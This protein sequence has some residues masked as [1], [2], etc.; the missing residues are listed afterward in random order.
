[1]I[2]NKKAAKPAKTTK[3]TNESLIK[4]WHIALF[5]AAGLLVVWQVVSYVSHE[6]AEHNVTYKEG[7]PKQYPP[8]SRRE[9]YERE[10]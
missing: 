6:R 10:K 2:V 1:M 4:P 5:V 3:A 8:G 7:T 9:M